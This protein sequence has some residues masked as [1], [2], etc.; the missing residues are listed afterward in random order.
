MVGARSQR[1]RRFITFS[2]GGGAPTH[3]LGRAGSPP[4]T[5]G[6]LCE[7]SQVKFGIFFELFG[8]SPAHAVCRAVRL[9]QRAR[10]SSAGR[11][12]RL[13]HGVGGR[14]SLPRGVL[15]LLGTGAVPHGRSRADR[16]DPCRAWGGGLRATDEPP[17]PSR[18]A[19][20][21]CSTSC[22]AGVSSSAQAARAS[23]WT[24]LGGFG[25]DPDTTKISW[26]EYVHLLP[27]LWTEERV[28]HRGAT[29]S[30]PERPVLPKPVQVPAPADVGH[31]DDAGHR[32]DAADRGSAVSAWPRRA[33]RSRSA[34][35]S[36]TASASPCAIRS[37]QSST[38]RSPM[39]PVLPS[40]RRLATAAGGQ[41]FNAFMLLNGHL[42]CEVY[43][44]AG[45]ARQ[46]C[47][48]PDAARARTHPNVRSPTASRSATQIASSR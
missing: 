18:R 16:A 38:T 1:V 47:P 17:D 32:A 6:P 25:V 37:A 7:G 21:R 46:P 10:A 35:R 3:R 15:A 36:S 8:S 33:S 48:R 12:A 11:R 34:A 39:N 2:T 44:T 24:E 29:V 40:G 5:R 23:T 9:P 42:L 27:R 26:D 41:M 28:A 30:M 31:R 20:R 4:S 19:V 43:P 45:V 22:R 13:R 14:T